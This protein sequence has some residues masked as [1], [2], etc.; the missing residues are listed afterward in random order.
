MSLHAFSSRRRRRHGVTL[1]LVLSFVLLLTAVVLVFLSRAMNARLLSSGSL[2][3]SSSD[4]FALSALDVVTG[5][6]KQEIAS[7][8]LS[9]SGTYNAVYT[10]YRPLSSTN[11]VPIRFGNPA[12]SPDPTPNLVRISSRSD[13][14]QSFPSS[15]ASAVNSTTD[16]SVN[17][18]QFGLH[19]RRQFHAARLGP[20]HRHRRSHR[21]DRAEPKR[22]RP[23]RLRHL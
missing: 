8:T 11:A 5:N 2:K 7:S 4:Q 3:Q 12:G 20:R 16:T 21:P 10:V 13:G 15:L 18:R 19:P 1:I 14:S 6:L 23:L 22:H 9:S 17:G